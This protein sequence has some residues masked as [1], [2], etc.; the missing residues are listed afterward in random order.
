MDFYAYDSASN[1]L[2]PIQ[3]YENRLVARGTSLKE[4][5]DSAL[6]HSATVS[7]PDDLVS[8]SGWAGLISSSPTNRIFAN[9]PNYLLIYQEDFYLAAPPVYV[10]RIFHQNEGFY[11]QYHHES[12]SWQVISQE[13]TS[14]RALGLTV[15]RRPT[16]AP[17]PSADNIAIDSVPIFVDSRFPQR[18][19][20]Y[21]LIT[22]NPMNNS[23]IYSAIYR[24][25]IPGRP[26]LNDYETVP[27][28][29]TH[30]GNSLPAGQGYRCFGLTLPIGQDGTSHLLI[31]GFISIPAYL[32]DQSQVYSVGQAISA[33][34]YRRN[35]TTQNY[36]FM[37]LTNRSSAGTRVVTWD[38]SGHNDWQY[39]LIRVGDLV[40][41]DTTAPQPTSTFTV[42]VRD[43]RISSL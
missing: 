35:N 36:T 9:I 2:R 4:I 19:L 38:S 7:T 41:I 12:M 14:A 23:L 17:F 29:E 39:Q 20:P 31:D 3:F 25:S 27:T 42:S 40:H 10:G 24:E 37:E 18:I 13:A 34:I 8:V 11:Y 6:V 43:Q 15:A 32:F 22:A 16:A 26:F 28:T 21:R 30:L 5:V 1:S 33:A